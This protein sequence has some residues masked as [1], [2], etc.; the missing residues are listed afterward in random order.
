MKRLCLMIACLAVFYVSASAQKANKPLKVMTYNILHGAAPGLRHSAQ[1]VNLDQVANVINAEHPDL[2]A[3]QEVDSMWSRSNNQNQTK[4]LAEK[5]GL[6]YYHYSDSRSFT[7]TAGWGYGV[8]I[9]SRYPLKDTQTV[10]LPHNNHPGSENWVNA[11]ATVTLPSGKDIRFICGHFDY[12]YKDNALL[13]AS[14]TAKMADTSSI[15]V[16]LAGDLNSKPESAAIKELEKSFT[17]SCTECDLSFP[18]NRPRIKI[19]YVMFS[20]KSNIKVKSQQV[21]Y[22]DQTKFASDHLPYIIELTL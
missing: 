11:V 13:D 20:K 21:I 15:P 7:D 18:S 9:L 1:K 10:F 14:A 17:R 3:I 12:L 16:I 4:V 19:D 6:K 2:V 8:G 5:T 22:N